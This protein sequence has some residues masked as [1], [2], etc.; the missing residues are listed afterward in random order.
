MKGCSRSVEIHCRE[1]SNGLV[2]VFGISNHADVHLHMPF[3]CAQLCFL[4]MLF[5]C[6]CQQMPL[7]N[8]LWGVF[9]LLLVVPFLA[10][11]MIWQTKN[12]T[13]IWQYGSIMKVLPLCYPNVL[14][15]N[16]CLILSHHNHFYCC[17]DIRCGIVWKKT[18]TYLT[19]NEPIL[20]LN[21]LSHWFSS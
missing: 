5:L 11:Q 17:F 15:D 18:I 19:V 7:L 8:L 2:S 21:F 3:C 6:L 14:N 12:G 10:C 4:M 20:I 1:S 16:M 13:M 9:F